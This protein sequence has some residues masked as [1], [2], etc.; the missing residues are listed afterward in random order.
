MVWAFCAWT[1]AM[2]T[3]AAQTAPIAGSVSGADAVG[4]LPDR[5]SV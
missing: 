2:P 3:T 5:H 1:A 4:L